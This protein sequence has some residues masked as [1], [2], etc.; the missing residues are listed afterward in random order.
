VESTRLL[1]ADRIVIDGRAQAGFGILVDE[2]GRIRA[3]DRLEKLGQPHHHFGRRVLLPGMVN[4]HSHAFQ[5]L[6][7]GRTQIA[8]E[9]EDNFWSWRE[10]MYR[11]AGQLDPEGVYVAARQ[12]FVEMLLCGVTSVGEF[13]YLHHQVDGTPYQDSVATSRAVFQAALDAGI[14]INLLYTVFLRGDFDQ[15]ASGLQRRFCASSLDAVWS[16]IAA[17]EEACTRFAEPRLRWS[18][19]AHSVRAVPI[20]AIVAV[21]TCAAHL[22]MHIHASEQLRE[23]E[24]CVARH[25]V[26]PVELLARH[27]VLDDSTVL[28]H[29][30]HLR[31][32]EA[33]MIGQHRAQV[34]I[35][36]ST[37]ADLGDGIG[38]VHQLRNEGVSI[39]LGTDGQ[40]S[41]SVLAETQRLELDQRLA[42]RRRNVLADG[43]G[44]QVAGTLLE[45]ATAGGARALDLQCGNIA[46]GSWAD[47]VSFNLDDPHLAG[48]DDESMLASLLLSC[49]SRAVCDV[50]VG[51]R[52][53]VQEGVHAGAE[54][55]AREF[56]ALS[57]QLFEA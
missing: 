45:A 1:S 44:A 47:L 53:V 38:P 37:E 5:R 20:D 51:G 11:V 4:G 46:P 10:M 39:S 52:L 9:T 2:K 16:H 40:I 25:G 34:C 50:V 8:G 30:T 17:L 42:L 28:V 36:P 23:V 24:G 19:A 27:G 3:V 14:R 31:E 43:P 32:G 22:M 55:S 13:H 26:G 29:A 18:M 7:R 56:T 21:K 41:S 57:R 6:L 48:C 54:A 33:K 49:D 35:C 15:P 12:A